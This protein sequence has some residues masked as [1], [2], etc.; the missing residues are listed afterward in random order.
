VEGGPFAAV[1]EPGAKPVDKRDYNT[2]SVALRG[3]IDF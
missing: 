2:N 3:Q 1:V